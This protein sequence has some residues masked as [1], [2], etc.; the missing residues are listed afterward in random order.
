MRQSLIES[1]RRETYAADAAPGTI[2]LTREP[3]VP[4]LNIRDSVRDELE[5]MAGPRAYD[6]VV[7]RL[8]PSL[9][10]TEQRVVRITLERA[11]RTAAASNLNVQFARLAPAIN[12]AQ[13]VAAQAVFDWVFFSNF[14][15]N[16]TDEP[17]TASAVGTP[18]NVVNV[19]TNVQQVVD[20]Q[21]G[22]RK[23]LTS[24]GQVTIQ[25]EFNYT[26]V[27][28]PNLF[29]L[30]DPARE[31]NVVLQLDQPLL[32][33]FGS[34]VNLSQVRLDRNTERDE[35]QSLKGTLIQNVTDTEQAYWT[36][37][38]A[39]RNLL[40]LQRLYERGDA[41]RQI[42]F[43]RLKVDA[44]PWQYSDAAARVEQ[45]RAQIL[46]AQEALAD[47]SDRLK[48]LMNDAELTVGSEVMLLPLDETLDMPISF[49]LQDT[50]RTAF[51]SR[52]EVQRALISI[53]NTSIRRVVADNALLPRLD[54]RIQSQFS[55]LGGST[56]GAYD[57]LTEGDFINYGAQL[58]FEQP[59][60]NREAQANSSVRRLEQMQAVI[61]FRNT[62]QG[63]T[64]EV[65]ASLRAV[66]TNYSLI[67]QT[68][69]ARIAAAENLR[70]LQVEKELIQ[71]LTA[72][73]LNL[74]LNR[75]ELLASAEQ[76]E[77]QAQSDYNIALARLHQ[78]MGT[79]LERNRIDFDVEPIEP[80]QTRW[81]L[82]PT[83][84]KQYWEKPAEMPVT[85][86]EADGAPV[87]PA[88]PK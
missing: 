52:P 28:T 81:P 40:I 58:N 51:E 80:V 10:P 77:V 4:A 62:I 33:N 87:P 54:A 70:A 73:F 24:G 29:V 42:V 41:T 22:I 45:R 6:G 15:W 55:G 17:R 74:E 46:R 26:D 83:W 50:L 47:A 37:V 8:G 69:A 63:I 61:A 60:G 57:S 49:S 25:H 30:P 67:E 88:E 53:D 23:R 13:I 84:L 59:I 5:G 68:R 82:L 76:D 11:I 38:R 32:R 3:R 78:A 1:I 65:N 35:I 7:A 75:Q 21:T 34:D 9:L 2:D 43:E 27:E 85:P 20:L 71:G 66:A 18:L 39:Y 19:R 16:D 14:Q 48:Q 31:S 12:Q 86:V 44:K 79:A 72:E 56:H 36:L 64:V